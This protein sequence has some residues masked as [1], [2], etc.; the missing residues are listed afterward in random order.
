MATSKT[1]AKATLSNISKIVSLQNP[2]YSIIL[3]IL[4]KKKGPT[5]WRGLFH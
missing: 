3:K 2:A 4:I 5:K 1:L